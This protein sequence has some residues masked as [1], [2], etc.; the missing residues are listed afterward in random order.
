MSRRLHRM[1]T[2]DVGQ[3]L[4]RHLPA[5][6]L[7]QEVLRGS[8]QSLRGRP[9][10]A[11]T[12]LHVREIDARS[13]SPPPCGP[14][15]RKPDR[16][17]A[18]AR[19][20][21]C[22]ARDE[23]AVLLDQPNEIHVAI[24]RLLARPGQNVGRVR[25]PPG[26]RSA[27]GSW[28]PTRDTTR[29]TSRPMCSAPDMDRTRARAPGCV[30]LKSSTRK[31][32]RNP[33]ATW[34][35]CSAAW[36]SSVVDAPKIESAGQFRERI[37]RVA[38]RAG[39]MRENEQP[40]KVRR[41]WLTAFSWLLALRLVMDCSSAPISSC[42]HSTSGFSCISSSTALR[43]KEFCGSEMIERPGCLQQLGNAIECTLLAVA[44]SARPLPRRDASAERVGPATRRPISVPTIVTAAPSAMIRLGRRLV[45]TIQS[46]ISPTAPGTMV[47]RS[48]S[49]IGRRAG[50]DLVLAWLLALAI[51]ALR[52]SATRIDPRRRSNSGAR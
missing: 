47:K 41:I 17:L 3:D 4:L 18:A 30:R 24:E 31:R 33:L 1:P 38:H 28:A 35:P 42:T 46:T 10:E 8:C 23:I 16:R 9:S 51:A 48:S 15:S 29:A 50:S 25:A 44:R 27:G 52:L 12:P 19:Q 37:L 34:S 21:G 11:R 26:R 45:A 39:G 22:A 2:P 49:S 20:I 40:H 13:M 6:V 36:N 14:D 43:E 5:L 32:L 7:R